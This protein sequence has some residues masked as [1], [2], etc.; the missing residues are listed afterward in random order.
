MIL[1]ASLFMK[2]RRSWAGSQGWVLEITPRSTCS[3]ILQPG[4]IS[5]WLL[6]ALLQNPRV[7]PHL[8]PEPAIQAGALIL[9]IVPALVLLTFQRFFMQDMAVTGMEK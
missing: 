5:F 8:N 3:A 4:S 2:S 9:M 7:P 6:A 1:S